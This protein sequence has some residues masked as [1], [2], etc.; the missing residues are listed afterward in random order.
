MGRNTL[1]HLG[2]D[3]ERIARILEAGLEQALSHGGDVLVADRNPGEPH[4]REG[5][6]SPCSTNAGHSLSDER[7][8]DLPRDIAKQRVE[9]QEGEH[10]RSEESVG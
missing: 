10:E 9:H 5:A 1:L 2:R 7:L 8:H 3:K 4:G 6:P